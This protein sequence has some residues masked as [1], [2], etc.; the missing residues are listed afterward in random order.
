[1]FENEFDIS[2]TMHLYCNNLCI[3]KNAQNLYKITIYLSICVE[4][5]M[6][7]SRINHPPQGYISTKEY[8]IKIS[9]LNTQF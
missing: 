9:N 3:L 8:L 2:V 4:T 6:Y 5:L 1:L 7:I